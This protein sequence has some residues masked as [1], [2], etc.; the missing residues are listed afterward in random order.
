MRSKHNVQLTE[1]QR[2]ELE[3]L[4]HK[5]NAAARVQNRARILLLAD[6]GKSDAQIVDALSVSKPT[7]E[8]IRC[9]FCNEG[10]QRALYH[11]KGSGRPPRITGE[12]EAHLS[13]L[14]CSTP[15]QGSARWTLQLLADQMVVLGYIDTISDTKVHDILKK[16]SS[17]LGSQSSGV[18]VAKGQTPGL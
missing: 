7:V 14:A 1:E 15:P 12:V 2:V 8:R 4:T 5:G 17:S 10:L 3:Q 6:R 11:K 9:L 18:S 16:T 13:M